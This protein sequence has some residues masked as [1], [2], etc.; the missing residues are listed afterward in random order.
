MHSPLHPP[1]QNGL[2]SLSSFIGLILDFGTDARYE[3]QKLVGMGGY[4]LIW[5]AR[6]L[7]APDTSRIHRAIKVTRAKV[8]GWPG[9]RVLLRREMTLHRCL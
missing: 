1:P 9:T 3:I 7:S 6:D 4:G 8:L 2:L 5:L